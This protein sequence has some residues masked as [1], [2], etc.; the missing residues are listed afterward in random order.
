MDHLASTRWFA[1]TL[2]MTSCWAATLS[3]QLV[4]PRVFTR[5]DGNGAS[6]EP[7][8]ST[9]VLY[10]YMQIHDDL[11]GQPRAIG[12]VAFRLNGCEDTAAISIQANLVLSEAAPGISS[13]N[14]S[15]TFAGNHGSGAVTVAS[16]VWFNLPAVPVCDPASGVLPRP[17]THQMLFPAFAYA[18]TRP[19]VWEM[20]I[21]SR[22]NA[23]NRGSFDRCSSADSNPSPLLVT[24]LDPSCRISTGA[25]LV[26]L[27]L[28]PTPRWTGQPPQLAL[29]LGGRN[30]DPNQPA[31]TFMGGTRPVPSLLIPGSA[32]APSGP[33]YVATNSDLTFA[34]TAAASG[35]FSLS[36]TF[37]LAP[38]MNGA[39]IFFQT[40][41]VAPSANPLGIVSSDASY[42]QL[43]APYGLVPVSLVTA[44]GSLN[45]TGTIQ[46]NVGLV[47]QFR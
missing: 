37:N 41:G 16:G 8:A 6:Q 32:T 27:I 12:G 38:T 9:A 3:A 19:L 23:G 25:S 28:D 30:L 15:T 40:F 36:T 43:R 7:I 17:F 47:V 42:M 10:R 46:R 45:A 2:L 1:T 21:L 26:R 14:L 29:T 34:G 33:C 44:R 39:T 5:V 35:T 11:Q 4:S 22:V 20:Q 31:V 18:G 24:Y 13:S